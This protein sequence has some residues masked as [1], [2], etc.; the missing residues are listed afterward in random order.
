MKFPTVSGRDAS[1]ERVHLPVDFE[2]DPTLV[3]IT[4]RWQQRSLARSWR[5]FA[6]ELG[7]RY[8]RFEFYE[9]HV[10]GQGSGMTPP[11]L[12]GGMRPAP[13]PGSLDEHSILL[14]VDR[15]YF[16]RSLGLLG[17]TSVYAM[18]IDD[19]HVVRQA[20]G[21]LTEDIAD[22]LRSLLDEWEAAEQR[23]DVMGTDEA[24][25]NGEAGQ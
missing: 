14:F 5:Q 24:D 21:V 7:D 11:M 25:A 16:Q 6:T 19:G 18:L 20:A 1:G 9:L 22:G 8:D 12:S 15:D 4:F 3:L 13:A 17:E 10:T 23:W 2:G